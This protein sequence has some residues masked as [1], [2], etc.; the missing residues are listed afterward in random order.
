LDRRLGGPQSRYGRRGEEKILDPTGTRTHDFSVDEP[1][2]FPGGYEEKTKGELT[3]P[4]VTL[5]NKR[6]APIIR[7]IYRHS[8]K[9]MFRSHEYYRI[10][11]KLA[12]K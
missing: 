8:G 2:G 4:H 7:M 5:E 11:L 3:S 10:L 9:T 12:I 1:V 6:S